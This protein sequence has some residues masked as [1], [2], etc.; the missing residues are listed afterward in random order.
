MM[1]TRRSQRWIP[2]SVIII[3]PLIL[4]WPLVFGGKVLYWGTPL[5]Q[6]YPWRKLAVDMIRSGHVPLWN[7]YLGNGTPLAANLQSAV[8]YPLNLIYLVTTVE[9][10]MGY[11]AVLHVIL[12][13]LFMYLYS[14]TIRLSRFASL[15]A[16][17][18]YMF[19][20]FLISRLG[21]LSM[22]SATPWLPL[23][24]CLAERMVSNRRLS[25]ALLLG[26]AIGLQLLAGHV[27]LWYYGLWAMAAYVLARDW[28]L[29]KMQQVT[30]GTHGWSRVLC[31]ASSAA[32]AWLLL[33]LAVLVGLGV[34]AVQLLPT[35]ELALLSQRQSGAEYEFAMT[36]S[37]WPW[38][39]LT[40]F[41]PDFFG[42]PARGNYWGY[43]N[44]WEDCGYVGVL[45]LLLA[46]IAISIYLGQKRG[47]GTSSTSHSLSLT[48]YPFS[49]TLFF[50]LLS[51]LSLL[52]A[53]G[54]NLPLYPL[55]FRW[56]PG[57]GFFQ[58]PARF[59][60]LYTLGM[61]TLAGLGADLMGPSRRL[62][63]VSGYGVV[64]G[65]AILLATVAVRF[66][67]FSLLKLTFVSASARFAVLL[68]IASLLLL[69]RGKAEFWPGETKLPY[70][71]GV[72]PLVLWQILVIAFIAAD[73]MI[74]G[75][76]LNPTT[77]PCL[78]ELPTTNG[79][80]LQEDKGYR[81][82]T[83]PGSDYNLKFEKYLL[84]SDFGPSDVDWLMGLRETLMPNLAVGEGLFSANNFDPLV[85]G[86]Y[87]RLTREI[88]K[89]LPRWIDRDLGQIVDEASLSVAL[90]LLS[91]MN[92]KYV[93]DYGEI[94][95]LNLVFADG[96]WIY[97]N[98]DALPRAY[99]VSQAWV[100][101]DDE[102]LLAELLSQTFDPRRTVLLRLV[103][104]QEPFSY[105][106]IPY[107]LS[108]IPF[109]P[110]Y[111]PNAVRIEV[112]L[113]REGY[114]VLSDTY[115]PG[116]RA[117]VDGEEKE[118]LR[119]NYAF[120]AI[121]LKSGRHTVIFKYDPLSFKMGFAISLVTWGTI[122]L[123]L[124]VLSLQRHR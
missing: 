97:C 113:D 122:I 4:F 76:A 38:R 48:S 30:R 118:V 44:Y 77:E 87:E 21:F 73:L 96:V 43:A 8:F 84:L 78:Y 15:V 109:S 95:G 46:L 114:L 33:A 116:W 66:L 120:R 63:R 104:N 102:E 89:G 20:G 52:L 11:S 110:E 75:H 108:L 94:P 80:F 24:F 3:L 65:L 105:P 79:T 17:L 90:R 27:Q 9:R 25:S 88:D 119:A 12:A 57:F 67:P 107:P 35:A 92:V 22:T 41:A 49:L 53:L 85:V 1:P 56:V 47:R 117:Y 6:F 34:A 58:A 103:S 68:T 72:S 124:A 13:G 123:C 83:F 71:L 5:L 61:A 19:S 115:Y 14:R 29:C 36:Y 32:R 81:I 23:L 64:V 26:L 40:F 18:S 28:Q 10:A 111:S 98:S 121:P 54:K 112:A 37:F 60:Y 93:L 39:L 62:E 55:V 16:A 51:L 2:I 86:H 91:L 50:S 59:L 100:I 99:V 82:F 45:P 70:R 7:H 74:F 42:N 69:Y 101:S 106:L 31:L